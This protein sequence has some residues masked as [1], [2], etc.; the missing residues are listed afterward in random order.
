M[1]RNESK[2]R[3]RRAHWIQVRVTES[4]HERWSQ[5]AR[6][7]GQTLTGLVRA[8]LAALETRSTPP[9]QKC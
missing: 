5:L 1:R 4:E 2:A 6:E 9:K 3:E 7:H 8:L